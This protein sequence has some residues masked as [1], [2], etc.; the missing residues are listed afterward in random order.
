MRRSTFL[1]ALLVAGCL[2]A[3]AAAQ[4]QPPGTGDP[5]GF[6]NVLGVGQGGGATAAEIADHVAFGGVPASFTNQLALYR[7]LGPLAPEVDAGNLARFFKPAGFGVESARVVDTITP[8]PGV[9]IQIDDLNVPHVYGTTRGD[10]HFGAGYATGYARMFQMD[11]LRH[12]AR[13]TLTELAGLGSGN[14][15]PGWTWTSSAWRTTP[16]P[17][18]SR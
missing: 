5:G 4:V 6:N 1:V 10:V 16:R 14:A 3:G 2:P 12:T 7:D 9:V 11:V 18:S 15:N 8:R 13:G 17:S